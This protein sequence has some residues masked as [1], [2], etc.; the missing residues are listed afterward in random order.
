MLRTLC[1][2]MPAEM[3]E[4]DQIEFIFA[5]RCNTMSKAFVRYKVRARFDFQCSASGRN[6]LQG[7]VF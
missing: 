5:G 6:G 7:R 3:A 2:E 1:H 4:A